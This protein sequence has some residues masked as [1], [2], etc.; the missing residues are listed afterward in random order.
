MG[1]RGTPLHPGRGCTRR[2]PVDDLARLLQAYEDESRTARELQRVA[3]RHNEVRPA[4]H[5]QILT[6]W[7]R[8]LP[9]LRGE[10]LRSPWSPIKL[11]ETDDEAAEEFMQGFFDALLTDAIDLVVRENLEE[12]RNLK[13]AVRP[14]VF[15]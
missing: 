2:T 12:P 1:G 4:G 10:K 8:V 15:A 6:R 14:P 13:R 7:S 5:A 3:R 11:A 9:S